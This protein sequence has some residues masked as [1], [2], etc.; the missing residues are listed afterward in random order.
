MN[1]ESLPSII[2]EPATEVESD[3]VV[4]QLLE[5]IGRTIVIEGKLGRALLDIIHP[6]RQR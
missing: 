4:D 5:E 2:V 1:K 3:S 6:D